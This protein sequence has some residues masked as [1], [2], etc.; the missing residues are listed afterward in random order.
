MGTLVPLGHRQ[1]ASLATARTLTHATFVDPADG[2]KTGI[3]TGAK[4]AIVQAQG[5]TIRWRSDGV[6]PTITSG[7]RIADGAQV[8]F[9]SNLRQLQFIEETAGL[10]LIVTYYKN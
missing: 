5:G 10:T 3:P 6:A 9:T 2:A 4:Y 1:C 7:Q 8:R